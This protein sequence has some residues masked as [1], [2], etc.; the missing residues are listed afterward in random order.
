M[1]SPQS[2]DS[3]LAPPS[4]KDLKSARPTLAQIGLGLLVCFI[5]A[6][7]ASLFTFSGLKEWYP[8]LVK[9]PRITPPNEVFGPV[10]TV[11][12]ILMGISLAYLWAINPQRAG[13]VWAIRWFWIQLALNVGWCAMFFGLRSPGWGYFTICLL[14]MAIVAF[15]WTA[16]RLSRPAVLLMVPYFLWV[17]F[18]SCLNFGILGYNVLKPKVEAMD[19]DPRNQD[20]HY[21]LSKPNPKATPLSIE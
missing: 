17:T 19:R 13:R 16:S 4:S 9:P 14:W 20:P 12:Y 1:S 5:A 6:G 15:F 3:T 2:F 21:K 8:S 7:V 10:W 11:L 18:A